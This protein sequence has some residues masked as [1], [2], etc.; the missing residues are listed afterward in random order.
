M[1]YG[2][3]RL[4]RTYGK[5][6]VGAVRSTFLIDPAGVLRQ[7]WPKVAKV[8]GHAQAVLTALTQHRAGG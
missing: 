1:A 4:K 3:W 6:T 8:A 2:A 5:E 7:A